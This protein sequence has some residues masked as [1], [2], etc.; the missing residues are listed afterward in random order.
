M[1]CRLDA[2]IEFTFL[3]QMRYLEV[4]LGVIVE[5]YVVCYHREAMYSQ[6]GMCS[7]EVGIREE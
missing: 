2:L 3:K 6:G 5:R 4:V 7:K 1:L